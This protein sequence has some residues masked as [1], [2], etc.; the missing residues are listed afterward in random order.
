[1]PDHFLFL[2]AF[3]LNDNGI[4]EDN[5]VNPY[6]IDDTLVFWYLGYDIV[7]PPPCWVCIDI[8]KG[9]RIF[10]WD[11]SVG[12]PTFKEVTTG[13][14]DRDYNAVT[15]GMSFKGPGPGKSYSYALTFTVPVSLFPG[16]SPHESGFG[17]G[18]IQETASKNGNN[19]LIWAW[20]PQT[21]PQSP[22]ISDPAGAVLLGDLIW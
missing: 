9:F 2:A 7:T 20:P 18:L 1:M 17:F 11:A 3:D 22:S 13:P 14:L 4:W 12:T 16:S 8:P 10:S 6:T 5:D 15:F 21:L 19:L